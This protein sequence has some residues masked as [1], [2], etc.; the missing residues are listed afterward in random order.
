MKDRGTLIG[1]PLWAHLLRL[2]ATG[3]PV[4]ADELAAA[5]GRTEA[6]VREALTA[7]PDT[8]YDENGRIV[9]SGLTQRPTPHRFETG[10]RQLYTWCALDTLAFPTLLGTTAHVESPCRATGAPIRLTVTPDGVTDLDPA[11]AVVSIVT[12]DDMTSVRTAFCNE[13][14]FFASAGA[15]ADWLSDRPGMSVLPVADAFRLGRPLIEAIL[16]GAGPAGGAG[17]CP[18]PAC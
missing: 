7:M 2:L 11:E 5:T 17:T 1:G 10:G 3:R 16:G 13:V 9:G 12:P 18:T 4:G 6:E 8:E 15:A 14:H